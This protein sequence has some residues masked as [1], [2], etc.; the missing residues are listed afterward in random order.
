MKHNNNLSANTW[1]E[2][3]S[4]SKEKAMEQKKSKNI[5]Y[6]KTLLQSMGI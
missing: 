2:L 6:D 4:I 5:I 1:I 3:A